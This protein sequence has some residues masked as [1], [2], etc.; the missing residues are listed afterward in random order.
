MDLSVL[1]QGMDLLA[2]E[3]TKK[4]KVKGRKVVM[5]AQEIILEDLEQVLPRV[6]V[7]TMQVQVVVL[8][9]LGQEGVEVEETSS[10]EMI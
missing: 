2:L 6:E 5:L 10:R 7:V 4:V 9:L 1:G 3:N 8:P